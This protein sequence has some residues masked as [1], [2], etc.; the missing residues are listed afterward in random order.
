MRLWKRKKRM[1]NLTHTHET[2]KITLF[3]KK[4]YPPVYL[5]F[6]GFFFIKNA[7]LFEYHIFSIARQRLMCGI[8]LF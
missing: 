3:P 5:P 4:S 1:L 2:T 7:I 8:L 6:L